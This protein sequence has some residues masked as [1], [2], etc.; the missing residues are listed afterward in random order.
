MRARGFTLVE[1][2]I[3]MAVLAIVIMQ[4]LPMLGDYVQ[5]ASVRRA[6]NEIHYAATL[7]RTEAI[8]GNIRTELRVTAAGWGVFDVSG[9]PAVPIAS[10]SLA[11]GVTADAA[12][13]GF[14]TNGRTFPAGSQATMGMHSPAG[15]CGSVVRCVAVR[16]AAGG[17]AVVCDPT[18]SAGMYGACS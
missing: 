2:V 13:V 14:G 16:V 10:G 15:T 12:V 4:G 7:A 18:K 9:D 3:V 17:G 6:A 1:L 8:K 11:G 5:N